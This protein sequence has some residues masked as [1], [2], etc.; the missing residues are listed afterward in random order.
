MSFKPITLKLAFC[1]AD[2]KHYIEVFDF[3]KMQQGFLIDNFTHLFLNLNKLVVKKP[4]KKTK[5]KISP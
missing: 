4:R 1:E 3:L 5:Q 2:S